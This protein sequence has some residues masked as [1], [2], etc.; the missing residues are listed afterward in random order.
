[1]ASTHYLL[2]NPCAGQ[3]IGY[4]RLAVVG[5]SA[6]G[7]TLFARQFV[8]T[9]PEVLSH[10]WEPVKPRRTNHT[11]NGDGEDEDADEDDDDYVQTLALTERFSST[12][13]EIPWDNMDADDE[14]PARN[15]VFL[16]EFSF[17]LSTFMLYVFPLSLAGHKT[18]KLNVCFFLCVIMLGMCRSAHYIR[19]S[20]SHTSH[21]LS[22][23]FACAIFY[24][25]IC[26]FFL[27]SFTLL[28]DT[29]G[30]GSVIDARTN[31]ALF[32]NHVSQT[33]EEKNSK[34]SPFIEVTNNELMRSLV[35]GNRT[36]PP[37]KRK[38]TATTKIST[39]PKHFFFFFFF[40]LYCFSGFLYPFRCYFIP[41][42]LFC[43][44][45]CQKK[46]MLSVLNVIFGTLTHAPLCT[47]PH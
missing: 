35:T 14:V 33:F 38:N 31:F 12:M 34:I 26:L 24:S 2:A 3:N 6:V 25:R 4:L 41:A 5:D 28:V 44:V 42:H 16:G 1:M 20:L 32:M 47:L 40:L 13:M 43:L 46:K 17:S 18:A 27:P 15:L 39:T 19:T 37:K 36:I 22:P 29:P 10:D 11:T 9:L 7:K 8:E 30:Y 21:T 45:R 23:P